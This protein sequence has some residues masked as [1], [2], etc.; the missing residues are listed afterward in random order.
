MLKVTKEE[1]V[2]EQD[3]NRLVEETYGK[4]YNFQQ[5]D[6]CQERGTYEIEVPCDYAE[7]E[8]ANMHDSIPE[9]INGTLMGV[10]FQTWLDRDPKEWNGDK[11]DKM[12][13]DL[14]WVRSFYP[15]INIL[16][17]DLYKRGLIK[18]GKYTINIDW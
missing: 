3:W 18:K 13:L 11:E 1:I 4:S 14:F 12:F 9:K 17:N 10:K 6:G 16:A 2:K 15:N 8:D 5:Q 7:E